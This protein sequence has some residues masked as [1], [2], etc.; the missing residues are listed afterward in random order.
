MNRTISKIF[1]LAAAVGASA[2]V[3]GAQVSI[4]GSAQAA[5]LGEGSVVLGAS[6]SKGG[7][8]VSPVAQIVGVGYRYRTGP[9]TTGNG[10]SII[11]SIGLK[12]QST[13]GSLTGLVGY[14]F[15]NG[16]GTP[17]FAFSGEGGS[18]NGV[19]ASVAANHWGDGSHALSAMASWNFKSDYLWSRLRAAHQLG[20]GSPVFA[21]GEFVAQGTNKNNYSA[22][23]L[24]VGPT[25]EFRMSPNFRVG[26]SGGY[27]TDTQSH[28]GSG[29]LGVEFLAIVP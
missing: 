18:E 5:G 16:S 14:A 7:P 26:A 24:Q 17:A 28:V 8:G 9:G 3:A 19:V 2:S 4:F 12:S 29:Y 21:G 25:I 27:R 22:Y 15:A 23:R 6:A 13:T 20:Q 10:S 1:A 11:P